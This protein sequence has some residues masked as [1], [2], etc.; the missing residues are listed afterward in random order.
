VNGQIG[1]AQGDRLGDVPT[2]QSK[3]PVDEINP[4]FGLVVT[5]PLYWRMLFSKN[6]ISPS[7]F[8]RFLSMAFISLAIIF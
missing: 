6:P 4:G 2:Q 3:K 5:A 8:S 7:S 1:I